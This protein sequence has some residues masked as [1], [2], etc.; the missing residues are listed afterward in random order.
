MN[1]Q[2]TLGERE[3]EVSHKLLELTYRVFVTTNS[4]AYANFKHKISNELQPLKLRIKKKEQDR[5]RARV[6]ASA[7]E[8][9][10]SQSVNEFA[11]EVRQ[12]RD[13]ARHIDEYEL[14][15][16]ASELS[17]LQSH[18]ESKALKIDGRKKDLLAMQPDIDKI[19]NLVQDQERRKNELKYNIQM[20][21][22]IATISDLSEA[23]AKKEKALTLIE[24]Y[25]TVVDMASVASAKRDKLLERK[26][27]TEGRYSEVVERIR[28]LKVCTSS[29][30]HSYWLMPYYIYFLIEFMIVCRENFLPLSTRV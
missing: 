8:Q 25:D 20:I 1:E 13:L 12:L 10:L 7:E 21:E 15:G 9:R 24:G 29:T 14:T 27:Q 16:R 22:E 11:R 30:L 3:K 26:A 23:I 17:R 6:E 5:H 19:K 28:G 4:F 18:L 2:K